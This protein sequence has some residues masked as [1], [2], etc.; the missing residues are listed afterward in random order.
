MK[1]SGRPPERKFRSAFANAQSIVSRLTD[2]E[3]EFFGQYHEGHAFLDV[4]LAREKRRVDERNKLEPRGGLAWG[5]PAFRCDM[6]GGHPIGSDEDRAAVYPPEMDHC[7][8]LAGAFFADCSESFRW[9][10][11]LRCETW[12]Q[13]GG[14]IKPKSYGESPVV[15][16]PLGPDLR[17]SALLEAFEAGRRSVATSARVVVGLKWDLGVISAEVVDDFQDG[18]F[19]PKALAIGKQT[20]RLLGALAESWVAFVQAGIASLTGAVIHVDM[21]EPVLDAQRARNAAAAEQC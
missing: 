7:Q 13:V 14:V 5:P 12:A 9:E 6:W 3:L 21:T 20:E 11:R 1:T 19:E 8:L 17:P 2:D 18:E 4:W 16:R 15:A 10:E